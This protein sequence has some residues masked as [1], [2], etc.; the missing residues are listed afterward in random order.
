MRFGVVLVS[1]LTASCTVGLE[2]TGQP[3]TVQIESLVGQGGGDG[4][5][6][7]TVNDGSISAALT[8]SGDIADEHAE[9]QGECQSEGEGSNL[10]INWEVNAQT[11]DQDESDGPCPI[12]FSTDGNTLSAALSID[13]LL[14]ED[15]RYESMIECRS[16]IGGMDVESIFEINLEIE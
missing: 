7:V 5:S 8:I 10:Q 9:M 11:S 2:E 15:G 12:T 14:Q 1:L 6:S 13:D 3:Q 4:C 16:Y